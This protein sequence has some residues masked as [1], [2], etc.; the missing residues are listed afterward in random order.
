MSITI[1]LTISLHDTDEAT[2]RIINNSEVSSK[3]QQIS[4]NQ[5][6]SW[7]SYDTEDWYEDDQLYELKENIAQTLSGL[8]YEILN[9]GE[10]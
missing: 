4:E 9:N 10:F 6:S 3:L 7:D 1:T 2:D 8:E 5:W